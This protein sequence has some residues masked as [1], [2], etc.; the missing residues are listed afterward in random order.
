VSDCCL[1]PNVQFFSNIIARTNDIQR[2]YNDVRFVLDQHDKLD[3][4][5]AI[6]LKQQSTDRHVAPLG[7]ICSF[8]LIMCT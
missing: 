4:Y 1:T 7:Y 6:S 8:S 2:D 5:R 3:F